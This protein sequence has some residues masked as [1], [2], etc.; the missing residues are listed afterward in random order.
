[1]RQDFHTRTV[2]EH[3]AFRLTALR[4]EGREALWPKLKP[5]LRQQNSPRHN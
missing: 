1:M 5:V 2:Q 4:S 3:P